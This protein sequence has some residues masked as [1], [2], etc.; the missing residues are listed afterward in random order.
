MATI[1]GRSAASAILEPFIDSLE[2]R[3]LRQ[4]VD[5]FQSN[6]R[7]RAE[8]FQS[9]PKKRAIELLNKIKEKLPLEAHKTE[10]DKAIHT[11]P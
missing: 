10:V 11:L 5:L 4:V 3:E 6:E 8:L 9:K 1:W 2:T 7:V